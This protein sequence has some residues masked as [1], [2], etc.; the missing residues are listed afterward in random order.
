[1]VKSAPAPIAKRDKPSKVEG[2]KERSNFLREPVATQILEDTT[3]F[4]EEAVQLLKFHGSYQQDNRDNRVKGQEK[5]YQFMLRT[6]NP[7]G[8]VPPQLYLAL[9]NLSDEHG[10]HTLRVTTRQGFQLHGILKKNLKAAIASIVKNMGSTL[11][12][13]G[14]LNR[15]VMAPPA[16]FKNRRDYQYAWEYA[17]NI[18]DL[19]TP[20]T[21]AYY[22]IWLDGEKIISA[23]ESPEVKAARQRNGTGTIIHDN[24]EPI[25]GTHYM[26]RKFKVSVTVPGDNS[27]DLYSQDLTLVVITNQQGELEGFNVFAGGGFGRTHNKEETFARIADEICYVD[28]DDVYQLVKAIVATQRDYGDRTERRHARLKYLINEWGVDNFRTQVED[29]FGKPVAP[30]KPL[31]EFKYYDFLGWNEQGDG[32]L[33]LGIS[34]DNGRVKDDGSFQLKTALREVVEQFNLP[35]RLTPHHNII[36]YDI[37]PANKSAIQEILHRCGIVDDPKTI[38]PL[39]RYAMAC[40]ALPTCSLAITES[41][42]AIPGI[43]ERIRTLLNKLG[44]QKEHFVVRMTGCPNGCARP[45]MA[46]LGF[47]GSAPESYQVWLG[48]SP[49]QTRLAQ[50]YIDR[51]HD[52]DIESFLEPIFVYFKNFRKYEES[53]GDFCDRLGFD[54]LREFAATYQPPT[55]AIGKSRHRVS[56]K[57]E[58]Y[59]KL[60][61]AANS[62]NRPMTELVNEALEAYFQNLP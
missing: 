57:D 4:T 58:V 23:E 60:K 35:M 43:L 1:M 38:E 16:P 6:R 19:L 2:I 14:D 46:E 32:K 56:L 50:P 3:H 28:K 55:T 48:G 44:L 59:L 5:D 11:G 15:N 21:G 61:E 54:A 12:A 51:L 40:P 17:N 36:F 7:G 25:Y 34:V 13:C 30:F 33:F 62:Q 39:V 27:V 52:N 20:Q 41:E 29:Y 31:P 49:D 37:E 8:F 42:R 45:Y 9:D 10:N 24:E 26:P 53:F 22:E 18:A 47:V